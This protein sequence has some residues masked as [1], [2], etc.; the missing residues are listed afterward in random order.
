VERDSAGHP[1]LSFAECFRDLLRH[2]RETLIL[3]WNW[4]AAF[5]SSVCRAAVFFLANLSTGLDAATGAMLAEFGY[6]A[7]TAGFYGAITQAFRAAEPRREATLAITLGLPIVSH[8][9]EFSV[10][11][12]R[13]T[14]NLRTSI[15]ASFA[16]TVVSTLF[17]LH[18]MRQ[19]VLVVG[20]GSRSLGADVRLLPR[21]VVSFVWGLRLGWTE[22]L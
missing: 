13:G 1:G 22:H 8:A 2:P 6:R 20:H 18:A 9:I 17:S 16:F 15:V 4:K 7:V 21:T 5:F 3:R 14:P 11:W 10:H 19:G 12:L